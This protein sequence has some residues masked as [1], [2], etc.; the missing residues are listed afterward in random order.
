MSASPSI[1]HDSTSP[2]EEELLNTLRDLSSKDSVEVKILMDESR[3]L[4]PIQIVSHSEEG[5][6][7]TA[8]NLKAAAAST[9]TSSAKEVFYSLFPNGVKKPSKIQN[10]G[11]SLFNVH[12]GNEFASSLPSPL[13][14]ILGVFHLKVCTLLHS[15]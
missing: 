10:K 5:Q 6:K 9:T 11:M 13:N 3:A 15:N 14:E 4:R 8:S 1:Q 7:S 12:R 2:R